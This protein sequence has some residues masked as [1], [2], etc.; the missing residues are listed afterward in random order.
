MHRLDFHQTLLPLKKTEDLSLK[1]VFSS[2][3]FTQNTFQIRNY[4]I[5][6]SFAKGWQNKSF[7]P[8]ILIYKDSRQNPKTLEQTTQYNQSRTILI[9]S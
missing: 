6:L 4:N 7:E 3:E 2:I 8:K 5:F 1:K 9:T